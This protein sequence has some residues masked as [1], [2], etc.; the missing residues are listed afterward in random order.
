MMPGGNVKLILGNPAEHPDE[1]NLEEWSQVSSC[2]GYLMFALNRKDWMAEYITYEKEL[3]SMLEEGFKEMEHS[4]M[5]AHL[6][7]I[8]G[9]KTDADAETDPEAPHES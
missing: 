3:E 7:V 1:L 9:G 6:R 4:R 5:R 2:L 8:D